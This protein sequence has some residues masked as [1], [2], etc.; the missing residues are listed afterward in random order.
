MKK[1]R[2]LDLTNK[3][4][5]AIITVLVVLALTNISLHFAFFEF[6]FASIINAFVTCLITFVLCLIFYG[7]THGDHSKKKKNKEPVDYDIKTPITAKKFF[8]GLGLLLACGIGYVPL[9]ILGGMNINKIN[10]PAYIKTEAII[11]KVVDTTSEISNPTSSPKYVYYDKDGNE[12]IS[13]DSAS[14]GGITFKVGQRV[15]VYY[16]AENPEIMLNLSSGVMMIMGGLFFLFG[17]CIGFFAILERENIIPLLF[18]LTFMVFS[19]G[20]LTGM[21]LASGMN[22][23]LLFASGASAYAMLIFFLLGLFIFGV[24][25]NNLVHSVSGYFKNKHS[26]K[27]LD[28]YLKRASR[29]QIER[30]IKNLSEINHRIEEETK[31]EIEKFNNSKGIDVKEDKTIFGEKKIEKNPNIIKSEYGTTYI[32]VPRKKYKIN[33]TKKDFK[34]SIG[35]LLAGTVFFVVGL[36]AMILFGIVPIAKTSSFVKTDATVTKVNTYYNKEGDFLATFEYEYYVDGQ[37]FEKESSYGQSVE[38]APSVGDKITIY[39][40]PKNP[41][42]ISDDSW[43]GWIATVMGLIFAG[44]G[45]GLFLWPILACRV[46][47]SANSSQDK[48]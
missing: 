16:N 33:F 37:K 12:I 4:G 40:N 23:F 45:A 15:T 25:V 6:S 41:D 13:Q 2:K 28:N 42:E 48:N 9:F 31:F 32:G 39:Y 8:G 43:M 36:F 47:V 21:K 19:G 29:E 44:V 34:S 11:M 3:V 24:G 26:D 30:D 18:G 46:A 5:I 22:I 27:K 14:W 20:L 1:K 10:S 38:I 17:G 35:V 7:V